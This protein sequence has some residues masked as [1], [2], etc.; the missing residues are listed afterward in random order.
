M[1]EMTLSLFSFRRTSLLTVH[2]D[3]HGHTAS[4]CLCRS[5][6]LQWCLMHLSRLAA[7][8]DLIVTADSDSDF[9]KK[10][11]TGNEMQCFAYD[12]T[13]KRQ[14]AAWVGETLPRLKKLQFQKSCVKTMLV[15]FFDWQGVIHKEFVPEG[16]TINAV[17]YKGVMGRLVNNSTC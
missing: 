7:C 2:T 3:L 12:P 8:R 16:E 14:S 6:P 4:G 9:F 15:V 17:Y 13:I 11:V 5:R 1:K 10:I